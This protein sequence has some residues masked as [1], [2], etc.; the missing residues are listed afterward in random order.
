[1]DFLRINFT[2]WMGYLASAGVLLS[3]LMRDIKKLRIVNSIGCAF[4]IVYG[5]L[6]GSIPVI[7]TNIAIIGVNFYYLFIKK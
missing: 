6:L 4:F 1:M 7:V 2:E 3:F 5:F